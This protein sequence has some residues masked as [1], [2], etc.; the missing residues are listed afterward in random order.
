MTKKKIDLPPGKKVRGYGMINDYGEFEFTPEQ[1]GV[2]QGK[3]RVVKEGDD[4]SIAV[5]DRLI[6]IRQRVERK[7]GLALVSEFMKSVN[8]V[9]MTLREYE[10]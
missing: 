2:R 7:N 4:F 5:T 9:L 1:T 3:Y 8:N 6:L 10:F